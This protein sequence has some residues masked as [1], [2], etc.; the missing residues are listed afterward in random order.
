[1]APAYRLVTVG[2]VLLTTMVAF[3]NM[4]VSTAMPSAA[5]DLEATGAYGLA[6]SSMMT[7]MLLGIVLAGS[8]ADIAGP[9]PALY[10]GPLVFVVGCAVC[11]LAPSFSALVAGRVLTGLGAG[12]VTVAELV[13]IGRIYPAALRPRVFTWL[14][15]AWVLPSVLGAP[16]AGAL[17]A[18]F[19][20]RAVFWVVIG[21]ALLA[22]P[23]VLRQRALAHRPD[24][25]GVD[26]DQLRRQARLGALVAAS[27]GLVQLA[28]SERGAGITAGLALLGL[29]GVAA[30]AP[31]LLPAG[32]FTGR[33]GLPSVVLSRALLNAAFSGTVTYVPLY[34]VRERGLSLP[35]AGMVLAVASL[36]WAVGSWVQARVT[37]EQPVVRSRLVALGAVLLAAGCAAV[38]ALAN[39]PGPVSAVAA[40]M[41]SLGLGMGLG[42]TSLAVLLLDLAPAQE[43]GRASAAVQVADVLGSVVGIAGA[44]VGYGL[45]EP[46]VLAYVVVW[47]ALSVVAAAGVGSGI[48][49]VPRPEPTSRRASARRW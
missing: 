21:P 38:A 42:S 24:D 46:D 19:S 6:F 15:A 8:W 47:A 26:H 34:L 3:E 43:H 22:M 37:G 1:M 25:S 17:A 20:W 11:A 36:G 14:S 35:A 27:C 33:R 32:T 10:A 29:A 49:C 4:A 12:V 44:T 41:V 16:V 7:A 9:R 39:G 18:A 23:L 48:R 40:C 30:G 45:L 2:L 31:R 28:I 13:A 5:A